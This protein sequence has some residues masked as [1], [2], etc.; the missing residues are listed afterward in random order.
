M[1][2]QILLLVRKSWLDLGAA[3]EEYCLSAESV[4]MAGN[5]LKS[6][7]SHFDAGLVPMSELLQAQAS[8]QQALDAQTDARTSYLKALRTWQDISYLCSSEN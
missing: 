7:R 1:D 8:L 4:Q 6:S 5:S 3:W 2:K